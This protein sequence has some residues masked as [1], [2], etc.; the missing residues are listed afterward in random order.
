MIELDRLRRAIVQGFYL[1]HAA[2]NA[3]CTW[4]ADRASTPHNECATRAEA[5]PQPHAPGHAGTNG[6][7][8]PL[9]RGPDA[10][11][12]DTAIRRRRAVLNEKCEAVLAVLKGR[13]QRRGLTAT[14]LLEEVHRAKG[15]NFSESVL[16]TQI[17]PTLKKGWGVENQP[18][19]GYFWDPELEW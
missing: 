8:F 3:P 12:H 1:R 16:T 13:G 2:Y 18:K 6:N 15:I 9:V 4:D 17:I 14:R 11:A 7:G 19:I 10:T 5:S